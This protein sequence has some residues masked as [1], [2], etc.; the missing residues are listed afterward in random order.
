MALS[1]KP[2]V[3]L[4][5]LALFCHSPEIWQEIDPSY[6]PPID[7]LLNMA[8]VIHATT[9]SDALIEIDHGRFKAIIITDATIT[10]T[11]GEMEGVLVKVKAYVE[12]GGLVIV[13]LHFPNYASNLEMN[14][15]FAAF[16]LPWA[17]GLYHRTTVQFVPSSTLPTSVN[18]LSFPGPY[19]VKALRIQNARADE[20][21]FVPNIG[22][23][24]PDFQ[25]PPERLEEVQP[26]VACARVGGGYLVYCEDMQYEHETIQTILA[27]CGS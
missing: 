26:A 19:E 17:A 20:K 10:N 25:L 1:E 14:R 22:Y 18:A 11:S 24:S 4:L 27:L 7:G 13:G 15:F 3:L 9:I 5:S 23:A 16:N 8:H 21:L 2:T 6:R 12:N